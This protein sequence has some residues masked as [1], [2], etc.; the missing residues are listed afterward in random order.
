MNIQLKHWQV[1]SLKMTSE[2]INTFTSAT[3]SGDLHL[4]VGNTF[5]DDQNFDVLFKIN[6]SDDEFSLEIE[7]R[8]D[9][10]LDVIMTE[11]FKTSSFPVVN[12][13]AIS[14]P[15]L[16]AFISNLTLQSGIK[17]I[18]LP[19]INFVELHKNKDP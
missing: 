12:A 14:F 7:A 6:L 2:N 18:I 19:S 1:T 13:P 3:S 17:P 10:Q 8:F 11:D 5:I 9:F 16:R 4:E 15:Y